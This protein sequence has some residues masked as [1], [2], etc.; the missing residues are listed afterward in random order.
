[1]INNNFYF[2]KVDLKVFYF[3]PCGYRKGFFLCSL[4]LN[5][6]NIQIVNVNMKA[7]IN[8]KNTLSGEVEVIFCI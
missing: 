2:E 6:K 5:E 4:C 1:M 3:E 7:Q 8:V